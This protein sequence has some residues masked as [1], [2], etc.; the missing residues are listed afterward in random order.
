MGGGGTY[1]P[2][3]RTTDGGEQWSSLGYTPSLLTHLRFTSL[4]K[5]WAATGSGAVLRTS[6]AAASWDSSFQ[7]PLEFDEDVWVPPGPI[8]G[9]SVVDSTTAYLIGERRFRRG[10]PGMGNII[11]RTTNSG[12]VW[13]T[14]RI[15]FPGSV[16]DI[17]FINKSRGWYLTDSATVFGTTDGGGTWRREFGPIPTS[18]VL[19]RDLYTVAPTHAWAVGD[20]GLLVRTTNAG[21]T[22][23]E[24]TIDSGVDFQS[25]VFVDH[26][27]GWCG[28]SY[29]EIFRT[30]DGGVT[31]TRL[32]R[33]AP[34]YFRAVE[35]LTPQ[36]GWAAS[37]WIED[38]RLYRTTDVGLSWSP[39]LSATGGYFGDIEMIDTLLGWAVGS[40]ASPFKLFKTT[41]AGDTWQPQPLTLGTSVQGVVFA[42]ARHGWIYGDDV[43]S[44]G[45]EYQVVHRTTNGGQTWSAVVLHTNAFTPT[46]LDFAALDS[47]TAWCVSQRGVYRT[48]DG[49][50][51]WHMIFHDS[52][53]AYKTS[54]TFIDASHGWIAG[55]DRGLVLHTTDGGISWRRQA[56]GT[57]MQLECIRF[58]DTRRG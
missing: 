45:P 22:W 23:V 21:T 47:P 57:N 2:L 16:T 30:N 6:N 11:A 18:A 40:I 32:S 53:L 42:D 50:E 55:A 3:L 15:N 33:G 24:S 7:W 48:L 34:H 10:F 19:L 12:A 27:V 35:F 1:G 41:N 49:G 36:K 17:A 13:D 46:V 29:G 58:A 44:P 37:G 52:S 20:R 51:S 14:V 5:G 25:I 4:D 8:V 54:I 9:L 43:G 56:S 38:V 26:L 39:Q 28:G 31:W